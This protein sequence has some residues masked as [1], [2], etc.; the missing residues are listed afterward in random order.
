[1]MIDHYCDRSSD[2]SKNANNY[3]WAPPGALARKWGIQMKNADDREASLCDES[4]GASTLLIVC[5]C[6]QNLHKWVKP[7]LRRE[8]YI[9]CVYM[10][11]HVQTSFSAHSSSARWVRKASA[12]SE[13]RAVH[14]HALEMF[15][16]TL[17]TVLS[18][19]GLQ[20][21]SVRE[22]LCPRGLQELR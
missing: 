17:K 7:R 15:C 13:T 11:A 9:R 4:L 20:K 10:R 21:R 2:K 19:E 12:D 6:L 1:M 22:D 8:H 18:A 16:W 5:S 3:R 14:A